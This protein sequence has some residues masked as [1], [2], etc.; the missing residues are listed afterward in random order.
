MILIIDNYDS[1][2]H[3]L[4]QIIAEIEEDIRIIRNDEMSVEEIR[5]LQPDAI[6]I[7][8]GP[9]HPKD[10]GI[11]MEVIRQLSPELPILGICLGHQAIAEAFG[12]KVIRSAQIMHGKASPMFHK[13]R[14]IFQD[15]PMP[16]DAG[17][18]HSLMIERESLPSVLS[19][20]AETEDGMIMAIKH[21]VHPCYGLQ[22]HPESILTPMGQ[23]LIK[24][25][26]SL[27]LLSFLVVPNVI[28]NP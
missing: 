15:M 3:N 20:E 8:P 26:L 1:F 6:I 11:S 10:A 7:S 4:Y 27:E 14:G 24:N 25:F 16:F 5:K 17:R 23:N 22:F 28:R 13:G 18:Y 2:T 12:G 19:I 21:L 9:G